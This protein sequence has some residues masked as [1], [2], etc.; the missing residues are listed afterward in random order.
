MNLFTALKEKVFHVLW[1]NDILNANKEPFREHFFSVVGIIWVLFG[2]S[3]LQVLI[4]FILETLNYRQNSETSCCFH[5]CWKGGPYIPWT[6]KYGISNLFSSFS[7]CLIVN[8][9]SHGCLWSHG[10]RVK[11]A[12]WF[13]WEQL[14]SVVSSPS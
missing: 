11:A 5:H 7:I 13:L 2:L 6:D 10:W 4:A 3:L 14:I 8:R 1:E 12:S 9:I